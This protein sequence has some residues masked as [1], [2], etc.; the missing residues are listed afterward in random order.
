MSLSRAVVPGLVLGGAVLLA[1]Q[2]E[3]ARGTK[4]AY[5]EDGKLKEDWALVPI[6]QRLAISKRS[7]WLEAARDQ[8]KP[9]PVTS[10]LDASRV[11]NYWLERLRRADLAATGGDGP[12]PSDLGSV[13]G[14]GPRVA[15]FRA[16]IKDA[17]IAQGGDGSEAW[18]TLVGPLNP[19]ATILYW[20]AIDSAATT[21]HGVLST[22]QASDVTAMFSEIGV[23]FIG[24]L[25]SYL[26]TGTETAVDIAGTLAGTSLAV[27]LSNPL[28]LGAASIALLLYFRGGQGAAS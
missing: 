25:A 22:I 9:R 14:K 6:A 13:G 23:N 15:A 5:T 17:K 12:F 19:Q 20:R 21:V 10:T 18:T 11:E 4:A 24:T 27:V 28:V 16:R 7:G 1:W 2:D 3:R 8:S 26:E